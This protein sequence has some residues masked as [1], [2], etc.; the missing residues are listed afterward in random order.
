M[1]RAVAGA[2]GLLR[3]KHNFVFGRGL[4][5][6]LR[7]SGRVDQTSTHHGRGYA[8]RTA[9]PPLVASSRLRIDSLTGRLRRARRRTILNVWTRRVSSRWKP[10]GV[11]D[12]KGTDDHEGRR[13]ERRP[14]GDQGLRAG[15][16]CKHGQGP[17]RR[18]IRAQT[19]LICTEHAGPDPGEHLVKGWRRL[20]GGKRAEHCVERPPHELDRDRLVVPVALRA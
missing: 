3:D 2:A 9:A 8:R 19:G 20:A 7:R 14:P 16:C 6:E 11:P 10:R 4:V 17:D 1:L 15:V 18:R 13:K 5:M 12:E